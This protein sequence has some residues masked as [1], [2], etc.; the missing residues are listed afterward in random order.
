MFLDYDFVFTMTKKQKDEYEK[1]FGR[2]MEVMC[3][4]GSFD[5]VHRDK[6]QHPIKL[7]Y[8]GGIYINRWK[9]LKEVKNALAQI[10]KNEKKAELHIYTANKLSKKQRLS[11]DDGKNSFVHAAVGTEELRELY[12]GSHIALHVESFALRNRLDTRLSFSTKIVDCLESGCALV[13]IGP[14]GQA[15]IEYLRENEA[16]LCINSKKNIRKELEN[17]INNEEQILD[18]ARKGIALGEKY[19][20]RKRIHALLD[21]HILSLLK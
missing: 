18:L 14:D 3:K 17:I 7:I 2:P 8:A 15:G 13:A 12:K 9:V 5:I 10:N 6:L 16:A 1:H 21:E 11:M 20:S 19:H 4:C